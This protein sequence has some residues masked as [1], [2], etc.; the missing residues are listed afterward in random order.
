[1]TEE[2]EVIKQQGSTSTTNKRI[3]KNTI[4]LYIRMGIS[5]LVSLYTSRVVLQTLGVDD[6]GIYNLVGGIVVTF[7][8]LNS[9]LSGATSRF[10]T[11]E[12]GKGNTQRLKD[13]FSTALLAHLLIAGFVLIIAETAGLWF[14][15]TQLV[16]P[17][18]RMFA[19][20]V[21]YQCSVLSLMVSFTQVPYN[22]S[23]ISHEKMDIF[24]YIELL[25]VFMRLGIVYLLVIGNFDKL[26]LYSILVLF[27]SSTIAII[28]R[29]YAI[30][31]FKECHFH[32]IWRPE[33]LKPLLTFSGWNLYSTSSSSIRQFGTNSIINIFCGVVYNAAGG[34]AII[35]N[36]TIG[37]FCS[38]VMTAF[39][40]QII[41]QYAQGN[42]ASMLKLLINAS[43]YS[44]I[45]F[46]VI[47]IPLVLEIPYILKLWLSIVPHK[48]VEFVRILLLSTIPYVLK[49]IIKMAVHASGQI[50]YISIA[51]G[52]LSLAVL[53]PTY[54]SLNNGQMVEF[55]YI[56]IFVQR[57]FCFIVSCLIIKKIIT[58][59]QFWKFIKESLL[60]TFIVSILVFAILYWIHITMETGFIR[61]IV[62]SFI[63]FFS[64]LIYTYFMVLDDESRILVKNKVK[65]IFK[66]G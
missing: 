48:T 4:L 56:W 2:T 60:G 58:E 35:I 51:D 62:V 47:S 49:E 9:S 57:C 13:T 59:F 38:S 50:K 23:I 15:S 37:G 1:M 7:Q 33:I 31:N 25:S 45:L 5:T 42:R 61:L 19:T 63:S 27:V 6:F 29:L 41:K 44:L 32:L 34:I 30:R 28:Y 26:I 64:F 22:A 36:A 53:I 21:V 43:K 46:L 12:L 17:R 20:Q 16:I 55:A 39:R 52:T 3:A 14:V 66:F 40:P 54:I 10:L 11:F 18:G 65:T 8:F 24:A